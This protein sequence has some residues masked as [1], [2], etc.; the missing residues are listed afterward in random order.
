MISEI[1][2]KIVKMQKEIGLDSFDI[3]VGINQIF[4]CYNQVYRK[5]S[6]KLIFQQRFHLGLD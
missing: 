6:D 1:R 5:Q 3:N 2:P 4:P